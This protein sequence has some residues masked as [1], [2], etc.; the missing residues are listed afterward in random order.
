M[1]KTRWNDVNHII[2]RFYPAYKK[3]S[4]IKGCFVECGVG[5]GRSALIIESIL[6]NNNDLRDFYLLDSFKGF[7]ELSAEDLTA[8]SRSYKGN[9]NW[10]T[11]KNLLEILAASS[12]MDTKSYKY[13]NQNRIKIFRG[14]FS[15]TINE[16]LL[17]RIKDS[18]G[19]AV[20]HLDV[21]LYNST[22]EC[23]EAFFSHV[24]KGGIILFDE[25]EGFALSKFPGSK[26]AIDEFLNS[27][28]LIPK[29]VIKKD[30]SGKY[31]MIKN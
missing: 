23:L 11:P 22:K 14:F 1:K 16:D 8:S 4:E 9:W 7:P 5:Y 21:D 28:D 6:Q 27:K 24:N 12:S 30:S 29:D 25:Y 15:N 31:Y 3:V 26:K 19:I 20:L 10:I 2:N 13:K 17:S 18:N